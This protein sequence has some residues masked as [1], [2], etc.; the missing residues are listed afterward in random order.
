MGS[1]GGLRLPGGIDRGAVVQIMTAAELFGP[2]SPD[3]ARLRTRG[4][5]PAGK[6]PLTEAMLREAPSGDLF[7]MT[8]NAGM[9]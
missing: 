4:P 1:R 9:G 2:F 5:G 7:G 3:L 6:L 8:Q